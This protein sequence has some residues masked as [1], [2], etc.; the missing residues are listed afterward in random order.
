M[1]IL[2]FQSSIIIIS[3]LVL[4]PQNYYYYT[5]LVIRLMYVLCTFE[6]GT[7][8]LL[9]ESNRRVL[10]A[11]GM[12]GQS[13]MMAGATSVPLP[14]TPVA[15]APGRGDPLP[16]LTTNRH[17]PGENIKRYHYIINCIHTL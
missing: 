16:H 2:I 11:R 12:A 6:C 8:C 15:L 7:Q 5:M 14:G 1:S 4:D 13:H 3:S 9:F 17:E 10:S